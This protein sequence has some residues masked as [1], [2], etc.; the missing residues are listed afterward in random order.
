CESDRRSA[1]VLRAKPS[2]ETRSRGGLPHVVRRGQT[3][4]DADLHESTKGP[5]RRTPSLPPESLEVVRAP[6]DV[7]AGTQSPRQTRLAAGFGAGGQRKAVR[8]PGPGTR[9][10]PLA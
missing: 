10:G 2:D 4:T 1:K 5:C 9:R 6:A 7:V 3:R 8:R